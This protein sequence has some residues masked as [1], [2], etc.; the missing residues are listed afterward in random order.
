MSIENSL[1]TVVK[2]RES[3][4]YE[5]GY[6][7]KT[8]KMEEALSNSKL[9]SSLACSFVPPSNQDWMVFENDAEKREE[10]EYENI[11]KIHPI[12]F[13]YIPISIDGEEKLAFFYKKNMGRDLKI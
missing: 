3:N 10:A 13:E 8:K 6:F 11:K 12:S 5:F 9:L 7:Y 1:Y 2:D 4:R